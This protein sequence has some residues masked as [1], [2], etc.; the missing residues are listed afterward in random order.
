MPADAAIV[1][2]TVE[3]AHQL[4]LSVSADGVTDAATLARLAE[5]GCD[6]AQGFHLSGPVTLE[7][8]PT[9]IAE[10]ESAVRGWIGTSDT[11]DV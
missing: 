6:V 3:L 11:A 4:G 5:F 10:L 1:R 7:M 2:S 8:L 9:R